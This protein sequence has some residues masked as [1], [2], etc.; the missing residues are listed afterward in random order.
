ML[1]TEHLLLA[2][3]TMNVTL[4]QLFSPSGGGDSPFKTTANNHLLNT[5]LMRQSIGLSGSHSE[6]AL[7]FPNVLAF[8]IY[9]LAVWLLLKH[10][11]KHPFL[12]FT[13][14]SL[15]LFNPYLIDFFSAARGYG[16]AMAFGLMAV[17]YF[18]KARE[19]GDLKTFVRDLFFSM[20]F[21]LLAAYANFILINLNIALLFLFLFEF[22]RTF[23][24]GSI[25]KDKII[26]ISLL[27]I[28]GL[29]LY[30]INQIY[31]IL[32]LLQDNKE[33]YFGG[34][35]GFIV[36]TLR[37]LI[38]RSIYLSYYGE[39]FWKVI[40]QG[41]IILFF[42]LT[43]IL[44]LRKKQTS[45]NAVFALLT[46]MIAAAVIQFHF[47]EI[48]YP[49]ERTSLFFIPLIGLSLFYLAA[50]LT[51]SFES[52]FPKTGWFAG[53]VFFAFFALPLGY[54]FVRNMNSKYILEWKID[55]NTKDVINTIQAAK[56]SVEQKTIVSSWSYR[57]S[58][59][60]YASRLGNRVKVVIDNDFKIPGDFVYCSKK[61][62]E[63]IGD[64]NLYDIHSEFADTQT[65]LLKRKQ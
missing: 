12:Y 59:D 26:V 19:P 9:G 46:V 30:H 57:P 25:T 17:Y 15:L 13:G 38:H 55:A 54:H 20:A 7:R 31:N 47:F 29:N 58:L 61:E 43:V 65:V 24:M 50:D 44:L 51:H 5:W 16:L 56:L 28:V 45:L 60:F 52:R 32:R 27:L 39:A 22:V 11:A 62:M 53:I 42:G 14:L 1:P 41:L 4:T 2:L 33:L 21:S 8:L 10:W 35:Q 63:K 40:Y 36:S 6:L 48:P 3:H 18:L 23:K 64:I 49:T 34:Q 37:L